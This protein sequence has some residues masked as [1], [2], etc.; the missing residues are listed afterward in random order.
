VHCLD[1]DLLCNR[2]TAEHP[3][4]LC[5]DGLPRTGIEEVIEQCYPNAVRG[6]AMRSLRTSPVQPFPADH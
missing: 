6:A 4:R 3:A 2:V 1:T 5:H